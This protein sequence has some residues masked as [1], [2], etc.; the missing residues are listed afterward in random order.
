[1]SR[2]IPGLEACGEQRDEAVSGLFC[3]EA[4]MTPATVRGVILLAQLCGVC[5]CDENGILI[6]C[7][8]IG[9]GI[10]LDLM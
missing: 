5:G 2:W 9:L 10:V 7:V 6:P 3:T 4:W 8:E 1:M